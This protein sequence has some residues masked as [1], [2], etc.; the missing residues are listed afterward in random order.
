MNS[1]QQLGIQETL[2]VIRFSAS[3]GNGLGNILEDGK[4]EWSEVLEFVPALTKLPTA[5]SGIGNVSAELLDLDETEKQQLYDTVVNE[6]NIPQDRTEDFIEDA[7]KQAL[8]LFSFVQKWF[9][10]SAPEAV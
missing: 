10:K 9:L 1:Q 8:D 6:F 3:F 7:L 5:V 4:F 2:D